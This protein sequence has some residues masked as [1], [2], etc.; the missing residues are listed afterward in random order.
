M[1]SGFGAAARRLA[2]FA[3]AVLGWSPDA[4]WRATPAELGAVVAVLRGDGGGDGGGGDG[5][6][7]PDAATR[8]RLQEAFPDG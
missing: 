5:I 2:G 4:F 8:A 7:P 3:G 6:D 1:Q